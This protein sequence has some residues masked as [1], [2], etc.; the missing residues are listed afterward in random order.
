MEG[1]RSRRRDF[2]VLF[3]ETELK[4]F[5]NVVSSA[6]SLKH[7]VRFTISD[8]QLSMCCV[9]V[10]RCCIQ[11]TS[12][13]IQIPDAWVWQFPTDILRGCGSS[14]S[15]NKQ[16]LPYKL[17]P[18]EN[19]LCPPLGY[20]PFHGTRNTWSRRQETKPQ[21]WALNKS[22]HQSRP[23]TVICNPLTYTSRTGCLLWSSGRASSSASSQSH[24]SRCQHWDQ[25]PYTERHLKDKQS[26]IKSCGIAKPRVN[27]KVSKAT[28]N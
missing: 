25:C 4:G 27:E 19:R 8:M 22:I 24:H 7:N 28:S 23:E 6:S 14:T 2:F 21:M 11:Y 16:S 20:R 9:K 15:K 13:T 18:H 10:H 3:F 17:V 12:G 1:V 26:S 5:E